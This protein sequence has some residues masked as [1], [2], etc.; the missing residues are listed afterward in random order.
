[1]KYFVNGDT[2]GE[3]YKSVRDLSG[4]RR[5]V[6]ATLQSGCDVRS[7]STI[8]D[9]C[10]PKELKYYE[11]MKGKE[12]AEVDAELERLEILKG[13]SMSKSSKEWVAKRI[14]I[15]KQLTDM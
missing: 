3:D 6:K 4:L 11:K 1:M 13:E 5:F 8:A 15:L 2:K 12:K 9:S 10:N 14:Y 7:E